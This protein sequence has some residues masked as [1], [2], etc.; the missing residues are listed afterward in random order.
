ME[1]HILHTYSQEEFYGAQLSVAV[2]GF[3]RP[4]MRFAGLQQLLGR[5]KTDIALA[6]LHTEDPELQQHA[7]A[8]I[9]KQARS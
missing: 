4:E 2:V 8:S 7:H 6:K 3:L 5:I 1:V 9:F